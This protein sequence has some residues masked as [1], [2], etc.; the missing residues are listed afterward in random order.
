[1]I[2]DSAIDLA[3]AVQMAGNEILR[4]MSKDAGAIAD[5]AT[6]L[7]WPRIATGMTGR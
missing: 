4:K 3:E 1:M 5:A 2:L 7:V 6:S